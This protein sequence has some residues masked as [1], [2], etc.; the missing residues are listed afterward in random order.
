M[1]TITH[2]TL[3]TKLLSLD[4][5]KDKLSSTE[6]LTQ[7]EF[8][9]DSSDGDKVYFH[10]PAGWNAGLK[11]EVGTHVTDAVMEVNGTEYELTK[12]AALQAT[13][14]IGLTRDYVMKTPGTL[15]QNHL[16]YWYS[17]MPSKQMKLLAV[18]DKGLAFTKGS[19]SPISN[20]AVLDR[21]L[22]VIHSKFGKEAEVMVDY[23]AH[24]DLRLSQYRLILPEQSKLIH[25]NRSGDETEDKW[26]IGLDFQNSLTAEAPL[27]AK[28]YLFAWW[29]TNGATSN[30][31]ASGSYSRKGSPSEE[32]ALDW[33]EAAVENVFDGLSHELDSVADLVAVD[34]EGEVNHTLQDVFERYK[35]PQAVRQEII[36][37]MVESEDLTMYGVMAAITAAANHTNL[38]PQVVK[39]LLEV[40]GDLPASASGRCDS[41]H[42][43]PIG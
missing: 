19:V 6:P 43:L 38:S 36:N 35:V 18:G 42:R 26:S 12:D 25:S 27:Q 3:D 24:H 2:E 16:N 40:G 11:D 1:T 4:D 32:D 31:A 13:S 7:I 28:G 29:C 34:I 41:C 23:K 8:V 17:V 15:V 20:L 14:A 30:H 37:E 33:I 21:A 5:L 39:R 10:L 9:P 22:Q